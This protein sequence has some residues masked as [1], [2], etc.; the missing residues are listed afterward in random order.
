MKKT[1]VLFGASLAG[2]AVCFI[3]TIFTGVQEYRQ[4]EEVKREA[5]TTP[6]AVPAFQ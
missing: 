4:K 2:I 1:S 6:V 3:M 5:A